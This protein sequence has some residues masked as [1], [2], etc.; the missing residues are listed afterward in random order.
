MV[1]VSR[2]VLKLCVCNV[3]NAKG[4]M[5]KFVVTKVFLP[6]H[7]K[8]KAINSMLHLLNNLEFMACNIIT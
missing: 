4:Q 3:V 1:I 7:S 2:V 6:L 8:K 5:Y